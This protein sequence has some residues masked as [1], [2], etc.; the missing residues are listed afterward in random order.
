[1]KSFLQFWHCLTSFF[2]Y[3]YPYSKIFLKTSSGISFTFSF[4]ADMSVVSIKFFNLSISSLLADLSF[5][6]ISGVDFVFFN[7][8]K[9]IGGEIGSSTFFT[10]GSFLFSS[11]ILF[12]ESALFKTSFKAELSLGFSL[13]CSPMGEALVNTFL[14]VENIFGRGSKVFLTEIFLLKS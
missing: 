8:L 13:G 4:A 9:E 12:S 7:S 10:S 5:D 14:I 2:I 6:T 1:M 3:L 11:K